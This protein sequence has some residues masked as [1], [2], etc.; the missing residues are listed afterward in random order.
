MEE[1]EEAGRGQQIKPNISKSEE[2]MKMTAE[3][4]EIE[5]AETVR[6]NQ[7]HHS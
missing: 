2:M 1:K 3:S 5:N 6:K 7:Y 4:N